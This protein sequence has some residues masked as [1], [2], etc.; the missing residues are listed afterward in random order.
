[1]DKKQLSKLRSYFAGFPSVSA[2]YLF[3]SQARKEAKTQSDIDIAVLFAE[4]TTEK[5][6]ARI[7]FTEDLRKLLGKNIDIC[8]IQ[9]GDIPFA[10]RILSESVILYVGDDQ[11]RISFEVQL[12]RNY[13]DMHAFFEEY[14]QTIAK[15]AKEGRIH[16]RPL[17]Y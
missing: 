8:D 13:F 11:R 7:Q 4:K 3:G 9:Q 15:L 6:N 14:Y 17:T 10:Y 12:L 2:V 16:A 1:M 5:Y